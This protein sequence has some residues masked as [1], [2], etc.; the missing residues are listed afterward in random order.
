MELSKH[1][2]AIN[3][4]TRSPDRP[5][6]KYSSGGSGILT[7]WDEAFCLPAGNMGGQYVLVTPKSTS[8]PK[9]S[10]KNTTQNIRTSAMQEELFPATYP[11]STYWLEDFLARHSALQ[12]KGQ[13]LTMQEVHCFL[14]SQ[15]FSDTNDP[16]IFYLRTWEAYYLTM[17]EKLSSKYLKFC[18]TL[19]IELNGN[20]LILK[21]S[22]YP[23]T[24]PECS[25]L[26]ILEDNVPDKYFLSDKAVKYLKDRMEANKKAGREF[27]AQLI[28]DM[29]L[30][31]TQVKHT[32]KL[33]H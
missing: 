31:E 11:T 14:R 16:D 3:S 24:G 23:R 6:L 8:T 28:P 25:L 5:S 32:S 15:G 7:K 18:P 33:A 10:T 21:T 2:L 4:Q 13:D 22:D 1:V 9:K 29:E 19:G 20:Y 27:A 17:I 12:E 26:D 30:Y